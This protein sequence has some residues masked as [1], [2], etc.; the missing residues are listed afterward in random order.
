MSNIIQSLDSEHYLES[1]EALESQAIAKAIELAEDD[2]YSISCDLFD[3]ACNEDEIRK[4]LNTCAA[5]RLKG[6]HPDCLELAVKLTKFAADFYRDRA[7]DAV[8]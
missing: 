2:D 4:L 1:Q 3:V 8:D 7:A 6:Q 5:Q